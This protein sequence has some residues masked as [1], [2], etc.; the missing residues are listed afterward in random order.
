MKNTEKIYKSPMEFPRGTI[1]NKLCGAKFA[2]SDTFQATTSDEGSM[3][4]TRVVMH[5]GSK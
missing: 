3:L 1:P 2:P 5:E 4:C